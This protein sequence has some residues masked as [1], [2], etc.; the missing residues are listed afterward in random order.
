MCYNVYTMA[1]KNKTKDK[2]QAS[3][4]KMLDAVAPDDITVTAICD[5]AEINRATFYYHY[6]SVKDVFADLEAKMER[7]FAEFI[8]MSAFNSDGTPAKSFYVTFIEFVA[9]NAT[10]CR[11][12]LNSKHSA[13]KEFLSRAIESGR[14]KV[15]NLFA[16][17][18]PACPA[19][20]INFY[21]LFVSNGFIALIEYWLNN[22][23]KESV[24]EIA[25]VG[26][27]LSFTGAKYL[28]P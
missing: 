27:R 14:Q 25:E 2:I 16:M 22:G 24:A 4:I 15:T 17:L 11:M 12:I 3:L 8:S 10:I 26:E 5:S 28:E 19:S 6:D 13:G 7:D 20:K 1:A 9:K 23:M 18:Y 21:Y